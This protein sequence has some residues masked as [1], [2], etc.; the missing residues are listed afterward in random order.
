MSSSFMNRISTVMG[1]FD[2][3][4]FPLSLFVFSLLFSVILREREKVALREF[5]TKDGEKRENVR[6]F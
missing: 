4:F 2:L 5:I 1:R 3:F 6:A